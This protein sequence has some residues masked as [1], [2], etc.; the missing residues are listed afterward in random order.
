MMRTQTRYLGEIVLYP[1]KIRKKI[2]KGDGKQKT[3]CVKLCLKKIEF[4]KKHF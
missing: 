4:N 2:G 3:A 1:S